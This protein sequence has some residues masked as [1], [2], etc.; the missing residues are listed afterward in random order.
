MLKVEFSVFFLVVGCFLEDGGYLFVAFFFSLAG[1]EGVAVTGLG[2]P[3]E[4]S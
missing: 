2:F 1:K 3:S 4:C